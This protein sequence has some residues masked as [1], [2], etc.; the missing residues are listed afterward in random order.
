MFAQLG[1]ASAGPTMRDGRSVIFGALVGALRAAPGRA[2]VCAWANRLSTHRT[3]Q[4]RSRQGLSLAL[5]CISER[6]F[7]MIRSKPT[8]PIKRSTVAQ[9]QTDITA[10]GSPPPGNVAAS[11]PVL[12]KEAATVLAPARAQPV[13]KG[14]AVGRSRWQR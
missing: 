10:E 11:E 6:K 14:P 2:R 5:G 8:R 3:L 4:D 7:M 1:D 9:Q 13:R 12:A